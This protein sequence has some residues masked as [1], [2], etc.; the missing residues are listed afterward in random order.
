MEEFELNKL[1]E[2]AKKLGFEGFTSIQN[3]AIPIILRKVNTLIISPT[4]TGKTEAAILPILYNVSKEK[5][6]KKPRILYITPLRALNRDLE[7]RIQIYTN[8]FGLSVDVRHGDT[9]I[10]KRKLM[11]QNPPDLLITTPET[12]SILISLPN[13]IRILE[14]IEW[15]II[16]EVHELIGSKRGVHLSL[17]LERLGRVNPN[18]VRIGLSA[19]IGAPE[20]AKTFLFGVDR[21]GAIV[22]D[23]T[24]RE[25]S[26]E[27]IFVHGDLT[28]VVDIALEKTLEYTKNNKSVIIFTN[29]R[30]TAEY[31][32]T[33]IKAK[34]P[35]MDIGVHHGS[36]SKENREQVE[37]KLREGKSQI[38]ITTSSLEL[39][40]D[41]GSISLVIQIDSPR[42]AVKLLQRVGRSEHRVGGKAEGIILNN[43]IDDYL[44]TEA[45]CKLIKRNELEEPIFHFGAL[46][47]LA[48][49]IVGL[50]LVYKS[51]KFDDIKE[52]IKKTMFYKDVKDEEIIDIVEMLSEVRAVRYNGNTV[53]RGSKCYSYYFNNVSMIP[54][55][56]QYTVIN[57]INNFKIGR[58]DQ[59]FVREAL[60]QEKPF[61]LKGNVWNVLSIDDA[62]QIVKVE[63]K[64]LPESEIPFWM[65]ELIPVDKKTAKLV[66]KIRSEYQNESICQEAKEVI[67]KTV[68]QLNTTIDNNDVIVEHEIGESTF[69]VHSCFGTRIN[70][71]LGN[72]LSTML[73]S[74][75]GYVV[76]FSSDPYRILLS[77]GELLTSDI[78]KEI[79]S[80]NADLYQILEVAIKDSNIM[81]I[82]GW[83]VARRFGIIPKEMP[84][85]GRLSG[86]ILR[87]YSGTA[88]YRE[89]L[90]EIFTD[91]FD[92]EGADIILKKIRE[93]KIKVI[94]KEVKGLSPLAKLG[95]RYKIKSITTAYDIS[96]TVLYAI[97]ERLENRK[98]KFLCLS[99]GKWENTS[100]TKNVT[101]PIKCAKCKSRLVTIVPI[102]NENA[103]ELI[104][105]KLKGKRLTSEE[106][107]EY[108]KLWKTSSLIQNFGKKAVFVLSGYGIGP[109][110]SVKVL[111]KAAS[112]EEILREIY[113]LEKKFIK[114]RPFWDD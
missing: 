81:K 15:V 74:K 90:N 39:G 50:A 4:G 114:T 58:V 35:E 1:I 20:K 78:I 34:E 89:V 44:E 110:N 91:K 19:T 18:F 29:T 6:R 107:N 25:Y 54:E 11:Q 87:R 56:T 111:D 62:T 68:Q 60:E 72:F 71:T 47:V 61:V 96:T 79:L 52:I 66:G 77:G 109:T 17:S 41:I 31:I 67:K 100:T 42:Q 103:S 24:S 43:S 104:K 32:A 93:N 113:R 69:V 55:N 88:F 37:L 70:N 101:E 21:K 73:S 105:N 33:L 46:D 82:R 85:D 92:I 83:H 27:N 48:H 95:F 14:N 97:K 12:F 3:K 13:F 40:M 5:E 8:Y 106:Q 94:I 98:H 38:V 30:Q 9:S 76:E 86:F 16:D 75:L 45:I 80:K 65:G 22:I 63:P 23:R 51:I 28:K 26:F 59:L 53:Y 102:W 10:S 64:N 2:H 49:H 112:E 57:A 108:R 84:Y 7:R 99:C 36:L